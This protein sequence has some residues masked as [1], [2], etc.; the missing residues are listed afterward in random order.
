MGG[1][2]KKRGSTT[3]R[4]TRAELAEL[5]NKARGETSEPASPTPAP[6]VPTPMSRTQTLHDP[7]TTQLLAEIARRVMEE[8]ETEDEARDTAH[9]HT[10]RRRPT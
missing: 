1:D 4:F 8:T 10:R 9:P 5:A 2:D 7:M 3:K 6:G